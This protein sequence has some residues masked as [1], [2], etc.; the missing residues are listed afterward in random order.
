MKGGIMVNL[1][2]PIEIGGYMDT[3]DELNEAAYLEKHNKDYCAGCGNIFHN[4]DLVE[5]HDE[6]MCSTCLNE[7]ETC[8]YCARKFRKDEGR[9]T[10]YGFICDGCLPRDPDKL[11]QLFNQPEPCDA[12]RDD[13]A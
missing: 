6:K 3:I 1:I 9:I 8:A 10:K 5:F 11:R 13:A 7:L 2:Q 4:D 12:A